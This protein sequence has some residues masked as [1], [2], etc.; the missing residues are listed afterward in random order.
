ML[1]RPHCLKVY[2]P[3]ID[4]D[5]DSVALTADY[6]DYEV[7]LGQITP[8]SFDRISREGIY[9]IARPHKLM[10][11]FEDAR[12]FPVGSKIIWSGRAFKVTQQMEPFVMGTIADHASTLLEEIDA[13]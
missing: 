10:V 3:D 6:P 11:N 2:P 7:V 1:F 4:I 12:Y 9:D 5:D 13:D 8:L